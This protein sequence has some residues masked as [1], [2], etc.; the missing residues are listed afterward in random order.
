MD[1]HFVLRLARLETVLELVERPDLAEDFVVQQIGSP[2]VSS[3]T[4]DLP[5]TE[6]LATGG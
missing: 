3:P 2:R 1:G 5:A 4:Q 6:G